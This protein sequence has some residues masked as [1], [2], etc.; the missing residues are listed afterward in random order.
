[1]L[2][3]V[4]YLKQ[5]IRFVFVVYCQIESGIV[6]L[7]EDALRA[8]LSPSIQWHVLDYRLLL[9]IVKKMKPLSILFEHSMY[10]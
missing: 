7:S 3:L 8:V 5:I 4:L 2:C 6:A 10:D 1:M 9:W